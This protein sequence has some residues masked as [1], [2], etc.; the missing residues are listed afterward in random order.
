[1]GS[2]VRSRVTPFEYPRRVSDVPRSLSDVLGDAQRL[3]TL[4]DRPID[5]VIAHARQFVDAIALH[6][7]AHDAASPDAPLH[8]L[9]MG[10]GAGVPG[11]VIAHDRGDTMLALV[12]RRETRMDALRRAVSAMKLTDRVNVVTADVVQLARDPE[13]HR[14]YDVVVSRGFGPPH[15]TARCARPFLRT[16]GILIVSEPPTHDPSRW[17]HDL[18]ASTSFADPQYHNGVVILRAI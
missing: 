2:G 8:I 1:M 13:H 17:P 4:G 12:D 7:L 6:H 3:G 15:E 5:E 11:L 10:T 14:A 9:D 16:G 18:C